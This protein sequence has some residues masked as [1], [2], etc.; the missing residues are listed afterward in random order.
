GAQAPGPAG[1]GLSEGPLA[2]Q[3]AA[4]PTPAEQ[5]RRKLL[6]FAW[7][8]LPLVTAELPGTGGVIRS[9]PEDFKVEELPAYE[10]S[11]RGSHLYLKVRKRGLTTRDLVQALKAR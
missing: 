11:G 4:A 2:E 8:D 7:A 1:Q 6:T 5:E 10:P 3:P 9:S